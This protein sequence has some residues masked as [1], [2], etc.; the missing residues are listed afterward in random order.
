VKSEVQTNQISSS[1]RDIAVKEMNCKLQSFLR[2]SSQVSF[3]ELVVEKEIG[4]G[5]YGRICLGKWNN[6]V[7]AL[8]FCRNK[9]TLD[10]F[11]DEIKVMLELPPHPNVIQMFGISLDGP[12]PVIVMEYCGGGS[13]DKLLF[14][15]NKKLSI[16]YKMGLIRSVAAGLYHLHKHNIVHRDLAARNILLSGS[17][18]P[19]ISDFGMSRILKET[20]GKTYNNIGPIRWMA[21]E[22]IGQHKY[23]KQSDVWTFGIVVWEI[24]RQSEPHV[25]VDPV[26]VGALIRDRGLAP[27]IPD[28]C[29][30]LLRQLMEM[31]WQKEP[32]QR[33][34]ID[35]IL[36]MLSASTIVGT[37]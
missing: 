27:K 15:S 35:V 3:K 18:E 32:E 14:D 28:N 26:D 36:A 19:K 17:G 16:E 37:G 6:G 7:V 13:L 4:E 8:K 5:S 21:P 2:M 30:P 11:V 23:S 24:V 34:P 25:D 31:C 1:D 20:E 10:T 22:S 33:P 29:P 12:Q 9:G